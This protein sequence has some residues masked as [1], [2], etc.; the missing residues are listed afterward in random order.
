MG[1]KNFL[2]PSTYIKK[3]STSNLKFFQTIKKCHKQSNIQN[4][5]RAININTNSLSKNEKSIGADNNLYFKKLKKLCEKKGVGVLPEHLIKLQTLAQ[6]KNCIIGIRPVDLMATDL[7]RDGYPTKGFKIKGKSANWGPQTAFICVNQELSKLAD[8]PEKVSKFNK[9]VQNCLSGGDAQKVQLKITKNRLELLK[10]KNIV[11]DIKYESNGLVKLKAKTSNNKVHKFVLDPSDKEPGVYEVKYKGKPIEVLAPI[12]DNK[13]P[14]TADYDL[15]MIAPSVTDFGFQD[16]LPVKDVSHSIFRKRVKQ[17]IKD[18]SEPLK[19][20]YSDPDTFYAPEDEEIGNASLRIRDMISDI[21]QHLVGNGEKVV[22]HNSDT[23]SPATDMKANFPAAF[24]LPE[25]LGKFDKI[26]V[27]KDVDE[28]KNLVQH[29]K[30]AG[31]YVPSNPLWEKDITSIR[32]SSFK[33]AKK[34]LIGHCEKIIKPKLGLKA[35]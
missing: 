3:N 23:G 12:G 15:F 30:D 35:D 4:L 6:Q 21:N 18:L 33:A 20:L 16:I 34:V 13:K 8:Q 7:I 5:R 28:L 1:I 19:E 25:T 14:L 17:Y 2:N 31:Y 22:H 32:S 10:Q 29:A 27:I 9:E 24:V 26:C 11:F